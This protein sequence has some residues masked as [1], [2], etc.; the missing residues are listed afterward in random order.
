MLNMMAQ[1]DFIKAQP[2]SVQYAIQVSPSHHSSSSQTTPPLLVDAESQA[3]LMDSAPAATTASTLDPP[4]FD[5]S[6]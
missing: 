6:E 5:W 2:P 4:A 1:V 3:Q